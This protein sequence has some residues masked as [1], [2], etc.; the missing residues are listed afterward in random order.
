MAKFK[1]SRGELILLTGKTLSDIFGGYLEDEL[2]KY[3]LSE[4]LG[5]IPWNEI[6]G[7]LKMKA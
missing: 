4:E 7:G 3:N 5:G 6:T 1:L 2:P